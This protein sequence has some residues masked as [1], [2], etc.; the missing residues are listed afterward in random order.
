MSWVVMDKIK[1]WIQNHKKRTIIIAIL[2]LIVLCAGIAAAVLFGD[3]R[4][5]AQNRQTIQLEFSVEDLDGVV[6]GLDGETYILAGS[7][8]DLLS[9]LSCDH[10]IVLNVAAQPLDLSAA[11]D[12]EAKYTFTV[13]AKALCEFLGREFPENGAVESVILASKKIIVVD[14]ET[15]EA[16]ENSGA[17]I[18]RGTGTPA[19]KPGGGTASSESASSAAQSKDPAEASETGNSGNTGGGESAGNTGHGTSGFSSGPAT[20]QK[21]PSGSHSSGGQ[22]PHTHTWVYVSPENS[23]H[24]EY[25]VE[26]RAHGYNG[27]EP[28]FFQT[29]ND[30]FL[31]QMADSCMSS[32]G[33]GFKGLAY[34]YCSGCGKEVVTGHVHD[35][36][37]VAKEV[38]SES[39]VCECGLSFGGGKNYTA[40][41]SWETHVDIYTSHGEPKAEH[42]SYHVKQ[43]SVTRY[44]ATKTCTCGWRPVDDRPVY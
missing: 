30:L 3:R 7:D 21:N 6:T 13:N 9:L 40:L 16:L 8:L 19:A 11:A 35:F 41:E 28:M 32:W 26:C 4:E 20:A 12:L 37:A 36:G 22:S 38:Y 10:S 24:M 44:E 34:K 42:D 2:L 33:H 43:T 17:V 5:E 23:G 15:A 25:G 27:E 29:Q 1:N 31:H 39:V 14:S 18:F